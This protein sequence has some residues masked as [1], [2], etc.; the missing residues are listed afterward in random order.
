M[1]EAIGRDRVDN[2]AWRAYFQPHVTS[3]QCRS[4]VTTR[5][6]AALRVVS[7]I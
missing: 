7:I 5:S 4:D 3:R 2:T 6:L 1:H